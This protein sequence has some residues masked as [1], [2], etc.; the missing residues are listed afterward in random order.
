MAEET[1][2]TIPL[3]TPE[4]GPSRSDPKEPPTDI[5]ISDPANEDHTLDRSLENTS[6]DPV[7]QFVRSDSE[8]SHEDAI[9]RAPK[10]N[11][12]QAKPSKKSRFAI[13]NVEDIPKQR[14]VG[15]ADFYNNPF[16]FIEAQEN[17][18]NLVASPFTTRIRD[19]DMPDGLKQR[20]FQKMQAE[21]LGIQKCSDESLK[22]YLGR[23]GKETLHM[24]DRSDGMMRGLSLADYAQG[25]DEANTENQL[26]DGKLGATDNRH[27]QNHRESSRKHKERYVARPT[28]RPN[29]RS[30]MQRPTF[31][32]LIK[33]PTEI[34]ATSEGKSIL[35]S[36]SRMVA[37]AHRR[38]R[39]QYYSYPLPEIDQKT[40]SLDGF[41]YKCFS[42]TYKGYH[43]IRMAEE[44]EEKIAFYMEQGTFCYEKMPFGLK[45]AGATYQRLDNTGGAEPQQK[46]SCSG[47]IPSKVSKESASIFQNSKGSLPALT[48]PIP[49]ETLTL[50]LAVS[51]ETV[52]SVLMAERRNIQR[53]IYFV[54]KALQGPEMNYPVLKKLA[55][56]LVHTTHHKIYVLTDQLIRQILLRPENS[57][58]LAKWAIQLGEHDISYKPRS[59]IK[60]QTLY[61]DGASSNEG[62]GA[63]LILTDPEGNEI[64]YTLRFEFPTSNNESEYEALIAGLELSIRIEVHHLQVFT[65]SLLV[66]NHV[67]GT[68]EAREESKKRYLEKVQS[69]QER[70]ESFS[71]THPRLKNKRADALIKLA[72]SSFAHL[73]K[74][75]LVEVIPCQSTEIKMVN[76]IE[77]LGTTWI[78]PMISYLEDGYLPE[79]LEHAPIMQ[80]YNATCVVV[81]R[82]RIL[83]AGIYG[84]A[85][86]S[87]LVFDVGMRDLSKAV[88]GLWDASIMEAVLDIRRRM[89]NGTYYDMKTLNLRG[90]IVGNYRF[91]ETK[92]QKNE[93]KGSKSS[94]KNSTRCRRNMKILEDLLKKIKIT[95]DIP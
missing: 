95:E 30:S 87:R 60:G 91:D 53:P 52:S 23:F 4:E 3:S 31:T 71:I 56:V 5:N 8:G 36:P 37:P 40:E 1:P 63:G 43:Q 25:A 77:E 80:I 10:E 79:D 50:Y 7:M 78:D 49:E 21:I 94:L 29:K 66:T 93:T 39:T 55:L 24:T 73:I 18:H 13:E 42:D 28:I 86:L 54:S 76:T 85:G 68:Y 14:S 34:Y 83:I 64:T 32:P 72:S 61:T 75:V 48:V 47:P 27:V 58:R 38:D 15:N 16:T 12:L 89:G 19:Y 59:A 17:I 45:N 88:Y 69:L 33:S 82:E 44:D 81:G 74:K 11:T 65:D 9:R 2:P 35:R 51:H 26:L 62:A 41:K 84:S 20:R 90:K 92:E 57:G 22:D 67:K 6:G 46:T 70:F